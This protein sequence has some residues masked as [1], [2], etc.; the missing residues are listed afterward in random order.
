MHRRRKRNQ[1]RIYMQQLM[2]QDTMVSSGFLVLVVSV[3]GVL[4]HLLPVLI[5]STTA[6]ATATATSIHGGR[7]KNR[8]KSA[9]LITGSSRGIGKALA[10]VLSQMGYTVFG[11]VRSESSS[12]SSSLEE[13]TEDKNERHGRIIPVT[14]DVTS[15][16]QIAKGVLVVEEY[17]KKKDLQ[18]VAIVNNAGINPEGEAYSKLYFEEGKRPP[19]LL[20]DPAVAEAVFATNV[21]GVARVT[22]A[23]Q[24]LLVKEKGQGRIV[25]IGSYFGTI[26]GGLGLSHLYYESTKFALEAL[27][28]GL[29]RGLKKEGIAVS[30]IKPGNIDTD[31]NRHAGESSTDVVSRDVIHAIES[32]N[33]RHRYYPGKVKGYPTRL[34][35]FIFAVLPTWLTDG[36]M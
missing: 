16:E 18:L 14:F 28:D 12:P 35:C 21:I 2:S 6:T 8:N 20:A 30:L 4:I 31:M 29:R 34:L 1:I 22:R 32:K 10:D 33:P 11:S 19:N 17:L 15:G 36:L 3:V 25:L 5:P 23:F 24:P 13:C 7:S 26:S 27:S 9:V